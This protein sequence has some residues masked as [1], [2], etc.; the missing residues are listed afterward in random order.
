MVLEIKSGNVRFLDKT[1]ERVA[2]CPLLLGEKGIDGTVDGC[3]EFFV[4]WIVLQFLGGRIDYARYSTG[5]L[6]GIRRAT[7]RLWCFVYNILNV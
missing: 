5:A 4:L 7:L 6:F 1:G 3:V 2:R